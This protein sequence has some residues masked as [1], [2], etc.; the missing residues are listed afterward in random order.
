MSSRERAEARRDGVVRARLDLDVVGRV[1]VD[2]VDLSSGEQ[3]VDVLARRRVA[4]HEPVPADQ[5]HVPAASRGGVGEP[6]HL[7]LDHLGHLVHQA[8]EQRLELLVA[9]ADSVKLVFGLEFLEQLRE[10][11]SVEGGKIARAVVGN[12][13]GN[14]LD[15]LEVGFDDL[16]LGPAEGPSCHVGAVAGSDH[17]STVDDDGLLLPE[18]GE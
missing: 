2:E 5:P 3:P 14:G 16:D 15:A 8:V 6:G 1:G 10:R 13:V 11:R 9:V 4:A 7:V 17:A 18:A 12:G